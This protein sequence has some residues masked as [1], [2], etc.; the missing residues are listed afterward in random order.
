MNDAAQAFIS[1]NS[2]MSHRRHDTPSIR[3]ALVQSHT[4]LSRERRFKPKIAR[5]RDSKAWRDLGDLKREL[6]D[7]WIAERNARAKEVM[8]DIK[9]QRAAP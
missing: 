3:I 5:M 4:G 8:R 9:G 1:F 6:L 2:F 7:M